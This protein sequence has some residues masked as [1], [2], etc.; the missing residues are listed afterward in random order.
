M[1]YPQGGGLTAERQQFRE[2]LRLQAA[3]RFARG[4]GSSAIAGDLRV[5]VRSVQRWR[6][7]GRVVCTGCW[8]VVSGGAPGVR[9]G[10]CPPES[11]G[12]RRSRSVPWASRLRTPTPLVRDS[13]AEVRGAGGGG[14]P[15]TRAGSRV[16]PCGGK[17][18]HGGLGVHAGQARSWAH[19]RTGGSSGRRC[20]SWSPLQSRCGPGQTPT[21]GAALVSVA[22]SVAQ[23]V[24]ASVAPPLLVTVTNCLL[25]RH[26]RPWWGSGIPF[27]PTPYAR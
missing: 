20:G 6:H 9:P 2:E 3:E 24:A 13:R 14:R 18:R 26:A 17:G 23:P 22:P 12:A 11:P 1:R 27:Y 16:L 4:E 15:G 5:S 19:S 21:R 25:R 10:V 7:A 8:T